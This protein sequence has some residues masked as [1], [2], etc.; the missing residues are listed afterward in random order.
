MS[1]VHVIPPS[2][3]TL[4]LPV[5]A[6]GANGDEPPLE[7]ERVLLR[8]PIDVRSVSMI[9]VA[10]LLGPVRVALGR[11]D[12]DPDP[13]GAAVQLR[14]H[15]A[16][17]PASC[18]RACRARSG[19]ALVMIALVGGVAWGTWSL[20]RPGQQPDR[21]AAQRRPEAARHAASRSSATRTPSTIDSVQKAAATLAQATDSGVK[22]T[23]GVAK[24]QIVKQSFNVQDYLFAG[25]MRAAEAAVARAGRRIHHLLPARRGRHVPPQACASIAGPNFAKRKITVQALDEITEQVQRYLLVQLLTSVVVG[26]HDGAGVLGAGLQQRRGVGRAGRRDEPGAVRGHRALI[27]GCVGGRRAAAVRHAADG[28]RRWAAC[29]DRAA[30]RSRATSSRR[31]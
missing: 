25:T 15:A 10:S 14:A 29:L 19:A 2:D 1:A 9:V 30:R 6:V 13:D 27:C 23:P 4:S 11:R 22:S 18:A 24:V 21:V 12:R 3:E 17:Q 20:E 28:R 7:K 5:Q 26:C 16:G 31:G 8:T